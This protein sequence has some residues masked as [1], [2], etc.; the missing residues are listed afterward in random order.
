MNYLPVVELY[1]IF[2]YLPNTIVRL[3]DNPGKTSNEPNIRYLAKYK[4]QYPARYLDVVQVFFL[5][6]LFL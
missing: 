2:Q 3:S 1:L 5:F 6:I 4:I